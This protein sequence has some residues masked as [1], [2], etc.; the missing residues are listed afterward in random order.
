MQTVRNHP[1]NHVDL[2]YFA[3]GES[4]CCVW[5]TR[6][7]PDMATKTGLELDETGEEVVLNGFII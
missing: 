7:D 2:V 5:N 6:K 4:R 1:F 3:S